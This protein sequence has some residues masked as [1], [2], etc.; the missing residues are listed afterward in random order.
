MSGF[1]LDCNEAVVMEAVTMSKKELDRLGVPVPERVTHRQLTQRC[2]WHLQDCRPTAW[3][4][5][6]T[7]LARAP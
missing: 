6:R 5:P 4:A 2:G 3:L 7:R 1:H